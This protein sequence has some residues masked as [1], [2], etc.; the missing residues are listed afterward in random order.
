MSFS[1]ALRGSLIDMDIVIR[2][3]APSDRDAVLELAP[4]VT[5]GVAPWLDRANVTAALV[6][7]AGHDV[8]RPASADAVVLVA[9]FKGRLEGFATAEVQSH[10]SGDRQVYIGL[11][12]VDERAE[13][14]GIGRTLVEQIKNWAR[15]RGA[16]RIMLDTGVANH[17]ARAFYARIGFEE[18]SVRLSSSV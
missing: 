6:G 14:G 17:G 16:H 13:R 18:E 15:G 2:S 9:E 12:A 11:L 1:L 7:F 8:A 10:W 4:R 3:Y 5:A